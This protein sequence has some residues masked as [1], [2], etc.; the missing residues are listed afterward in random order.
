MTSVMKIQRIILGKSQKAVS[1]ETGI[2]Q[3]KISQIERGLQPQ[4]DEA[5][6]IA[7]ALGVEVDQIFPKNKFGVPIF[8]TSTN[9]PG[10]E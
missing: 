2:G 9:N 6:R 4:P 1:K 7:S 3:W 5:A 10:N 8:A